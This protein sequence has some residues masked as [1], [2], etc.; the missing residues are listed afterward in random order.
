[1]FRMQLFIVLLFACNLSFAQTGPVDTDRPGNSNSAG[2]VPKKWLQTEFGFL[3]QSD[4]ITNTH[5]DVIIQHP[6]TLI[7]Y[8]IGKRFEF[9][10]VIDIVSIK[11]TAVNGSHSLAGVNNFQMG[12]KLNFLNEKGIIPKTSLVAHYRFN[13]IKI[14]KA[15]RDTIDGA[16][17]RL[18]MS[19]TISRNFSIGYNV[20]M[21]WAS[22]QSQPA[23]LYTFIPSFNIN[24]SWQVFIEFYGFAWQKRTPQNS[25]D[26]GVGYLLND[27]FKFD[28]S[29]G[30]GLNK[31]APDNFYSVGA[32]Y[33][34]KAVK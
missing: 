13:R 17:F 1:M 2:T 20:G 14:F 27:N 6:S 33:R 21:E 34:F 3:R 29:A 16:N 7:K 15:S 30:F 22:F 4:K 28:A 9:R 5:K 31:N 19:N 10:T 25:I 23:Y 26:F 12:G 8:G 18:A 24:D 32:S 11:E